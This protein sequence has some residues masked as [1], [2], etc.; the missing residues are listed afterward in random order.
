MPIWSAAAPAQCVRAR[1]P[2]CRGG[3]PDPRQAPQRADQHDHRRPPAALQPLRRHGPGMR[4][5]RPLADRSPGTSSRAADRAG[6][7]GGGVERTITSDQVY[8]KIFGGG[9]VGGVVAGEV[10]SKV[11][12]SFEQDGSEE[13]TGCRSAR[14]VCPQHRSREAS[15]TRRPGCAGLVGTDRYRCRGASFL[16]RLY[17]SPADE[18]GGEHVPRARRDGARSGR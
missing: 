7:A 4:S 13:S 18:R 8:I 6:H 10:V 12:H 16:E 5:S 11:P 15:A 1:R 9:N 14:P 2:P 3:G 17:R